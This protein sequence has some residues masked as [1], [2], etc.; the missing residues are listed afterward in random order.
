MHWCIIVKRLHSSFVTTFRV[1]LANRV[2]LDLVVNVAP[3]A[4]LDPQG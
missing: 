4:L 1:S 2:L 3:L